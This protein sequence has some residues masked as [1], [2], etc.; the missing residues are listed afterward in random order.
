M[1]FKF[2]KGR[3]EQFLAIIPESYK[4]ADNIKKSPKGLT[5]I[6][7]FDKSGKKKIEDEIE[8]N[9]AKDTASKEATDK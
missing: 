1:E 2:L 9:K 7:E 3:L 4:I 8:S 6:L 5:V